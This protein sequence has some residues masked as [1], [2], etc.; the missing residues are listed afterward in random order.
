MLGGIPSVFDHVI[1]NQQAKYAIINRS[2]LIVINL[3]D[4]VPDTTAKCVED[5]EKRPKNGAFENI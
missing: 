3:W 5:G 2:V 4:L 1:I